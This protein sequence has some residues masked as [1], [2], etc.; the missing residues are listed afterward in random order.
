MVTTVYY[1][2]FVF[3]FA[4]VFAGDQKITVPAD[5]TLVII[6]NDILGKQSVLCPSVLNYYVM[7]KENSLHNTPSCFKYIPSRFQALLFQIQFDFNK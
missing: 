1:L 4:L 5:E 6:R 3:Q 2:I 7:A